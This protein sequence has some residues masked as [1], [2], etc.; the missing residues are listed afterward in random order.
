MADLTAKEQL[1]QMIAG[2]HENVEVDEGVN[3]EETDLEED[4]DTT[5]V[6]ETEEETTES[7]EEVETDEND[8]SEENLED[9]D[10]ETDTEEE[11]ET[12][13]RNDGSS[14]ETSE[15]DEDGQEEN[16]HDEAEESEDES[17]NTDAEPDYKAFYEKVALAK[18]TANGREV[19]GFKDPDDLIRAQQM[20]HGYSDKMKV[21][22][23][24]KPYLKA[25]EERKLTS[26]SDKFNLAM[27]LLDG[28]PEA[29]KKVLKEQNI[30][31]MELDLEDIKYAPKNN[32]PSAAQMQIEETYEQA[33][34]LGISDTFNRVV[35]KDWDLDSVKELVSNPV[36]KND[37][38][39][40]LKDGTYD[41]VQNEVQR[42][43]LLDSTGTL[44]GMTSVD[45]YRVA[46]RRLQ[47]QQTQAPVQKAPVVDN[48]A[49]LKAEKT[50]QEAE[51][52]AKAVEKAKREQEAAE[53]RK[54]AASVSKK[55]A[56]KKATPA[57]KLEELKGDEFR[58]AFKNMLM[59]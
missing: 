26:D 48:T 45:K 50:K 19:E 57:P 35:T 28:D 18:F 32:L 55:K 54:K 47:K 52:K 1:E 31:P 51:F 16:A 46:V 5:E 53:A 39:Q 15:T 3:E 6:N 30:D 22:K 56:V 11:E 58:N 38:L 21:F 29:I 41:L 13:E 40:H 36:V 59:T 42:M 2:V 43:E 4:V 44:N 10:Q 25:L 8:E 49:A 37:L 20:L 33:E 9:T 27:S 34:N 12:D 7:E 14:E 17:E 24:Y 23:E